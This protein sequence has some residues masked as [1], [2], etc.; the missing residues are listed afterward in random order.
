MSETIDDGA[1]TQETYL[2]LKIDKLIAKRKGEIIT[3]IR[4]LAEN[5]RIGEIVERSPLRNVMAVATAAGADPEEVANFILYQ[6]GRSTRNEIWTRP[7]DDKESHRYFAEELVRRIEQLARTAD[8]ITEEA[9][10]SSKAN[11]EQIHLELIRLYLGYL[12][13]YHTYLKWKHA[14]QRLY[15]ER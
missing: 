9:G 11:R 15:P 10:R 3:N 8:D 14:Q 2:R 1:Q 7:P 13:R 12:G 6:L 5:Y 4:N